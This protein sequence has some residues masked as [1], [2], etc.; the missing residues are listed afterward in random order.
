MLNKRLGSF[1]YLLIAVTYT[2]TFSDPRLTHLVLDCVPL[3]SSYRVE[4][5]TP[6]FEVLPQDFRFPPLHS[7]DKPVTYMGCRWQH[8]LTSLYTAS[9]RCYVL[10]GYS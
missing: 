9:R 1:N 7:I 8:V 10:G 5:T 6:N 3:Y 2:T 4:P